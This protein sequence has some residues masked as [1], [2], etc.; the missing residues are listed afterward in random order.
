MEPKSKQNREP[1][2]NRLNIK[3]WKLKKIN[4]K[5]NKKVYLSKQK[6]HEVSITYLYLSN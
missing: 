6:Y 3:G 2:F 4:L 5:K 1:I